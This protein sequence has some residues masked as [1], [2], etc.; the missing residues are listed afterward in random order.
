MSVDQ[1]IPEPDCGLGFSGGLLVEY[2]GDRM[3]DFHLYMLMK[4]YGICSGSDVC[5]EAH[6]PVYYPSDVAWFVSHMRRARGFSSRGW[7][8]NE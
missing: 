3:G 8:P 5:S 2:L 6:G 4:T 1:P 7:S